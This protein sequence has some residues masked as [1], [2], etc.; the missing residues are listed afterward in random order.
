MIGVQTVINNWRK[1]KMKI[2]NVFLSGLA[3]TIV[4]A[5]FFMLISSIFDKSFAG[6]AV[7]IFP[8]VLL[9]TFLH[10]MF[11]GIPS[12]LLL[13][14]YKIFNFSSTIFAGF[15]IGGL[16]VPVGTMLITWFLGENFDD[17]QYILKAICSFGMLGIIGG[18]AFWIVFTYFVKSIEDNEK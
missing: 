9:T 18:V 8:F 1:L 16:P 5:L 12:I 11:F 15:I 3:A 2:K 14:K 7:I 6:W 4:P 17:W 13:R 10:T